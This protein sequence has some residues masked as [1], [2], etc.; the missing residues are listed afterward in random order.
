MSSPSSKRITRQSLKRSREDETGDK[1][2]IKRKKKV[3]NRMMEEE[4]DKIMF[5]WKTLQKL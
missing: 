5:Q 2:E 3:D 1:V 4:S